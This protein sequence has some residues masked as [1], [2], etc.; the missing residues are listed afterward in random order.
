LF[1]LFLFFSVFVLSFVVG[2]EKKEREG[3]KELFI[4][5]K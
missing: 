2:E 4:W 3:E 5:E 1:L